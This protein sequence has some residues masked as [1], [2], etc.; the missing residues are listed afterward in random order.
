MNLKKE[1]LGKVSITVERDY[2]TNLKNYDK[3]TI[4]EEKDT[5]ITYLSRKPVPQGIE[6]TNREYWIILGGLKQSIV[7]DYN[8]FKQLI[9]D[10]I[11]AIENEISEFYEKADST[12]TELK[13]KVDFIPTN[14]GEYKEGNKY[15][16]GNIVQ[17]E[18]G[19]YI[20]HPTDYDIDTNSLAYIT[21]P[22]YDDDPNI[23]NDG[24]AVFARA[25]NIKS[26]TDVNWD[27]TKKSITKTIN[28]VTS[29]VITADKLKNEINP[30]F[31]YTQNNETLNI[32]I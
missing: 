9:F 18:E 22:P 16:E 13:E 27:D 15:Y 12:L 8:S 14:R 7:I 31:N 19:S 5:F 1:Q 21:E 30:K 17:Y 23:L 20:A 2:H 28:N 4:V 32:V 6:L 26:V 25:S 11:D 24:W 3:L 10:K 29:D